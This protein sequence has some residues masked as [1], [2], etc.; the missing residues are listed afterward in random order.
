MARDRGTTSSAPA[1]ESRGRG[2]SQST[3]SAPNKGER[4]PFSPVDFTPERALSYSGFSGGEHLRVVDVWWAPMFFGDYRRLEDNWQVKKGLAEVGSLV[5]A[6]ARHIVYEDL[7]TGEEYEDSFAALPL[8]AYVPAEMVDGELVCAGGYSIEDYLNIAYGRVEEIQEGMRGT[9]IGPVPQEGSARKTQVENDKKS[10]AFFYDKCLQDHA[11]A[12]GVQIPFGPDISKW[13]IGVEGTVEKMTNNLASS[14]KKPEINVFT[15]VEK[16]DP[17]ID[18][19]AASPSRSRGSSG[20]VSSPAPPSNSTPPPTA[21]SA[22]KGR[23]R[24]KQIEITEEDLDHFEEFVAEFIAKHGSMSRA[25]LMKKAISD[26]GLNGLQEKFF[27]VVDPGKSEYVKD[28]WAASDKW[29]YEEDGDRVS[30]F[31]G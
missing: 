7:Q 10:N 23:G 24:K 25:D 19:T 9:L 15:V 28:F 27:E 12:N 6:L 4:I 14:K 1:P 18:Q 21:S 20:A 13:L 8:E 29:I 22:G 26:D 16:R 31:E 11:A 3:S 5:G 30:P 17:N 2:R